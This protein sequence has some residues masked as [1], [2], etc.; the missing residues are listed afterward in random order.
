MTLK[1]LPEANIFSRSKRVFQ[2]FLLV[3][4]FLRQRAAQ[5][6]NSALSAEEKERHLAAWAKEQFIRLGPT[7][8]KLGQII[9]TRADLFPRIW[10]EE[11]ATL[12]DKVDP[13]SFDEA[14]AVIEDE[15]GAPIGELFLSIDQEPIS[16][17]SL[18]QVHRARRRIGQEIVELVVKVQRPGVEELVRLDLSVLRSIVQHLFFFPRLTKEADLFGFL[19][20]LETTF[21]AELDYKIEATNTEEFRQMFPQDDAST[22]VIIPWV[23]Y[24][25][26]RK[27]V[28]TL[29]YMPG[30]KI[31]KFTGSNE[32]VQE[33]AAILI[34]AFLKQFVT[35]GVFHADPHPG[36]IAVTKIDG[37]VKVIFYDFGMI[38]RLSAGLR[39][40]I[41]LIAGNAIKGDAKGLVEECVKAGILSSSALEDQDVLGVFQRF[42]AKLDNVSAETIGVLQQQ[43][44]KASESGG[45]AFPRELTL[46]G[47]SLISIEGNLKALQAVYP[48]LNLG[49]VI[50]EETTALASRL[51]GE[52]LDPL[53]RIQYDSEKLKRLGLTLLKKG[54][55][56]FDQIERGELQIA[57]KDVGTAS[58]VRKLRFGAKSISAAILFATFF[59]PAILLL[60]MRRDFLVGLPLLAL[61]IIFLERWYLAEK[62]LDN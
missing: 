26:S 38:G 22:G 18:G 29:Q 57:V 16:T 11:F 51:L 4:G 44:F 30:T 49:S 8:I 12:Q 10:V 9:S 60:E 45:V 14:K 34:K 36:N 39:D 27:R 56:I 23:D 25:R 3:Y 37:K 43:L 62:R 31:S 54:R 6:G 55:T 50:S 42:T 59:I 40:S 1:L 58:A 61:S 20:E 46:V 32:D 24:E 2:I 53:E 15:L 48:E 21:F 28:L 41:L 13:F 19:N 47:R 17:A 35:V 52:P 7:F 5:A 33:A